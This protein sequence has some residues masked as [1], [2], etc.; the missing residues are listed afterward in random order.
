MRPKSVTQ[1][2]LTASRKRPVIHLARS[3]WGGRDK[4][5]GLAAQDRR[6]WSASAAKVRAELTSGALAANDRLPRQTPLCV[7]RTECDVFADMAALPDNAAMRARLVSVQSRRQDLERL[8]IW[9]AAGRLR[10]FID[11]S[12]TSKRSPTPTAGSRRS[13][14]AV[15]CWSRSEHN[16][17]ESVIRT[18][19]W[20]SIAG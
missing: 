2:T 17:S 14:P 6:S 1:A 7:Y 15:R 9:T 4:S 16:G 5:F 10:P 19:R 18:A 3:R 20:R 12:F 13:T 8:A 11:S